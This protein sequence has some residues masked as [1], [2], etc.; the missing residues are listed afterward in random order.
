M[1]V[2]P[3]AALTLRAS[4]SWRAAPTGAAAQLIAPVCYGG[5]QRR[6]R[7]EERNQELCGAGRG[8]EPEKERGARED[9]EAYG[10]LAALYGSSGRS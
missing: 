5:R 2:A 10:V 3:A 9:R 8:A 1:G 7:R 4:W 6:P